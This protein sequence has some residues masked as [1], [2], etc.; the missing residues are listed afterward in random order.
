M[1]IRCAVHLD[2]LVPAGVL[3]RGPVVLMQTDRYLVHAS[4]PADRPLAEPKE[5]TC[6]SLNA[7]RAHCIAFVL[8]EH[9]AMIYDTMHRV[10]IPISGNAETLQ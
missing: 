8:D 5:V 4:P 1:A 10:N 2:C 3:H 9:T 6:N 7:A